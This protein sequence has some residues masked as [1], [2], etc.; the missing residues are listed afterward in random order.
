MCARTDKHELI[1]HGFDADLSSERIEQLCSLFADEADVQQLIDQFHEQDRSLDMKRGEFYPEI[2][3]SIASLKRAAGWA[4]GVDPRQVHPNFGSNGSI[5][6]IM[7]AMK[8]REVNRRPRQNGGGMLVATPTYFRNYNS[9]DSKQMRMVKVPVDAEWQIDLPVFLERMSGAAPT[10]IFLVTPNN[11]T[12]IAI[13]DPTLV[14]IITEGTEEAVVVIDRTLVNI[15]AEIPTTEL[16]QRFAGRSLIILHSLSKY[17]GMSHLRVG[18][19]LYASAE[20][21]DEVRPHLP[22]G[23]GVEGAV[24]ATRRLLCEGAL[25]PAHEV[26]DN[27]R[28]AKRILAELCDSSARFACTDFVGNYG[29][30]LLDGTLDAPSVVAYLEQRG[31]YTMGGHG[32]PEPNPQVVRLHTGGKPEY[33]RRTVEALRQLEREH[34]GP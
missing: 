18:L 5:D 9:C 4:Y 28:Q 33:M 16:L 25:R 8:L 3:R 7:T 32:F 15:A 24:K 29:L 21:A 30:L 19:A 6:T 26:L 13:D 11:P 31:I 10:V 14:S 27:V 2:L 12:G 34:D 23:L 1:D 20:L 17:A 22:L